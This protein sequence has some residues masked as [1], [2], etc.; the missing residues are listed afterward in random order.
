MQTIS[1]LTRLIFNS[2]ED[3]AKLIRMLELERDIFNFCSKLHFGSKK[4]SI[5]ELHAKA[6][7]KARKAFPNARAQLV[8]KAENNCL[9]AYKSSKSCGHKSTKPAIKKRLATTFDK[10]LFAYK[11]GIFRFSTVD[12]KKR[13]EAKLYIYPKLATYLSSLPFG[14]PLL[15][16]R[17]QDVWVRLSF[18][19]PIQEIKPKLALGIDL[20]I[21][22]PAATSEGKIF[23]DKQYNANKRKI[24]YLKRCLNSKCSRGSKTAKKHL[25]KLQY[26]ERNLSRN[27][28]HNLTKQIL[29]TSA[30]TIILEDLSIHKLKTKRNRYQNKNR[31]SQVSLSGIRRILTYKA[32]LAGKQ[33][34][35]VSPYYTSQIDSVTGKRE[36]ERKGCRFYS[37]NGLVYDADVNAAVN[38][39]KRSELPISYG[40]I[41]DGQAVVNRP[42]VSARGSQVNMKHLVNN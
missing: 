20:G 24:R 19:I 10:R 36:G 25:Q 42:I 39:A 9:N 18:K 34:V 6:Y 2:D 30:D 12:F 13:I 27:F 23:I 33:V 35:C 7:K 21:R 17:N 5:V 8:I 41:L 15:I 3:K 40:S 38:I 4:N 1:C 28:N 26:K 31:I 11:D 32:A 29:K 16:V 37:V 22:R 14:D